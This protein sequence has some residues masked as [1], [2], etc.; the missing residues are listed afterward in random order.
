MDIPE[1]FIIHGHAINI[2]VLE[3]DTE[4]NRYGYYDSVKE[5]IVIFKKVY[6][7][8]VLCSLSET[9]ILHTFFHELIHAFQ[10]HLKGDTDEQ[11]AQSYAGLM[12]EFINSKK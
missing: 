6:S 2:Y 1:S 12:M 4:D 9:Q 10:W 8:G 3:V 5:E 11:E 7:S